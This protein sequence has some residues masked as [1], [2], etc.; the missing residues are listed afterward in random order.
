MPIATCSLDI[1]SRYVVR[2]TSNSD[3]KPKLIPLNDKKKK[4]PKENHKEKLDS[5]T[6]NSYH[7]SDF[8]FETQPIFRSKWFD[9]LPKTSWSVPI[10]KYHPGGFAYIR[11]HSI[12]TGVDLYCSPGEEVS[13]V[14]DGK[15]VAI[16]YFTGP[17]AGC[18]WYNT[19]MACLIEGKS[20]VVLYGEILPE[21]HIIVGCMV[22]SGDKIGIVLPVLKKDKGNGKSMLHIELYTKGTR[23]SVWWEHGQPQPSKLRNPTDFLLDI[24]TTSKQTTAVSVAAV[25][26][27]AQ[28]TRQSD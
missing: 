16:E 8:T 12:H 18:P 28:Q 23:K 27:S 2:K 3:A 14:E 13:A 26:A 15:V 24:I 1:G 22:K 4:S 25:S 6:I 19:T 20:G 21:A 10:G 17:E 5:Q 7:S 9:P 11:K